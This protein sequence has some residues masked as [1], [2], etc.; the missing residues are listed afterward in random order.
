M[1][2]TATKPDLTVIPNTGPD[3]SRFKAENYFPAA[4]IE[5]AAEAIVEEGLKT[6]NIPSP[7]TPTEQSEAKIANDKKVHELADRFSKANTQ[8]P[9]ITFDKDGLSFKVDLSQAPEGMRN[10]LL[11]ERA[12]RQKIGHM[13]FAQSQGWIKERGTGIIEVSSPAF[14]N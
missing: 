1:S 5:A 11:V 4:F 8:R 7:R 2:T 6:T 14:A 10:S 3:Y 12:I 9:F 13:G